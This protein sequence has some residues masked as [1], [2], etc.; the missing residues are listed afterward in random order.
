MH[1]NT[2]LR[3]GLSIGIV[4]VVAIF[5]W[6]WQSGNRD[7]TD[8][9]TIGITYIVHHPLLEESRQG[10]IEALEEAGY[11]DGQ[12]VTILFQSAQGDLASANQIIAEYMSRPVDLMFTISTPSTK[13]AA[14]KAHGTPIVFAAVTDPREAGI[15]R[16]YAHPEANVTGYSNF[17][18]AEAHVH[19]LQ[20]ILPDASVIG[21]PYNPGEPSAASTFARLEPAAEAAGITLVT[22]SVSNTADVSDAVSSLIDRCD[23]LYLLPDNTLA[24]AVDIVADICKRRRKPLLSC[25]SDT[26]KKG[27]A[28]ASLTTDHFLMG[29]EAGQMAI[30]I[31]HGSKPGDLPV[32]IAD[33]PLIH[34]NLK[35]A[36]A[37]GIALPPDDGGSI[38]IVE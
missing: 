8:R 17:S 4:L 35:V 37:L 26:V 21:I 11:V 19:F 15:V 28:L 3:A 22:A 1:K 6:Q 33:N 34:V 27:Q 20:T 16:D 12:T 10:F 7:S 23:A 36:D 24:S 2:R 30:A 29:K 18:P 31:L 13:V 5:I 25:E 32:R 14:E 9:P 38:I